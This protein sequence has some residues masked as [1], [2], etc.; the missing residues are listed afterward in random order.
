MHEVKDIIINSNS[1][2]SNDNDNKDDSDNVNSDPS[3]SENSS[4][5]DD[6]FPPGTG[7]K[8]VP[9]IIFIP[10]HVEGN[11]SNMGDSDNPRSPI[12]PKSSDESSI[13]PKTKP[14]PK[15]VKPLRYDPLPQGIPVTFN[16]ITSIGDLIKNIDFF[17]DYISKNPK[18]ENR[19]IDRLLKVEEPLRDIEQMVGMSS[20]KSAFA[21]TVMSLIKSSESK[22]LLNTVFYGPPGVGK[23]T[24]AKKYGNLLL[25]LGFLQNDKFVV[26]DKSKLVAGYVGQTAPKTK[27]VLESA[28]GGVLFIDEAYQLGNNSNAGMSGRGF[29]GECIDTINQFILEHPGEIVIILAGYRDRIEQGFFQLNDGLSRRFPW[30]FDIGGYTPDDLTKIF[31]LKVG[32]LGYTLSENALPRD[33]FRYYFKLF[34]NFGGDIELFAQKCIM[35]SSSRRF[36]TRQLHIIVREDIENAIKLRL[37]QAQ[38]LKLEQKSKRRRIH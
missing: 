30:R 5:D 33:F 31:N 23:T 4:S 14:K 13:K 6:Y 28:L 35:Y 22:P 2:S 36:G 20:I 18:F 29:D 32:D 26:A 7:S 9:R 25:K 21:N 27:R 12:P 24:I 15:V 17:K 38:S 34:P 1:P 3:S 8:N 37:Q 10:I 16:Q 11:D 19:D